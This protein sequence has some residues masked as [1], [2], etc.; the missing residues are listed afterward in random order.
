MPVDPQ[1]SPCVC[2]YAILRHNREVPSMHV[3]SHEEWAFGFGLSGSRSALRADL[4]QR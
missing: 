1:L 4:A 2:P 3:L